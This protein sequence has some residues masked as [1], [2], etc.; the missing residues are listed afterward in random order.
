MRKQVRGQSERIG[1]HLPNTL[2]QGQTTGLPG[3]CG[4]SLEGKAT[5]LRKLVGLSLLLCYH[6]LL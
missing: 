4:S 5:C 6:L 2:R 3:T 1:R